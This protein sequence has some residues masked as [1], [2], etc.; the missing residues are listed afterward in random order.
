MNGNR[1]GKNILTHHQGMTLIEIMIALAIFS[2]F[3]LAFM[4]GQGYNLKTSEDLRN[5][6]MLRNITENII[7]EII[8]NPPELRE[9]LTLTPETR[10]YEPDNRY[11]YSIEW[12]KFEI[13]EVLD[14]LSA[15][16][17]DNVYDPEAVQRNQMRDRINQ[18]IAT[19]LEQLIWQL[20]ITV[21]DSETG[22]NFSLSTFI[23]NDKAQV[24]FGNF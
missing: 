3:I 10:N 7:N 8:I 11:R 20:M 17:D 14:A 13:K 12:K 22:D 6:M 9:S 4:S 1:V 18:Q 24:S 23:Y 5:E 2:I 19:N 21:E 15:G 16:G